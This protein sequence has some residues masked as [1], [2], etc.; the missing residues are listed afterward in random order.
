M[1]RFLTD[2]LAC[3]LAYSL[4]TFYLFIDLGFYARS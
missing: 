1:V 2:L 4:L 3:V